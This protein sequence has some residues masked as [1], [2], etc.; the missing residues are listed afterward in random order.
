MATLLASKRR[1][2]AFYIYVRVFFEIQ[3]QTTR[4]LILT[5]HVNLPVLSSAVEFVELA[6]D[7]PEEGAFAAR[8]K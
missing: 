1:E 2:I 8:N 4:S 6:V 7:I 5:T 3:L